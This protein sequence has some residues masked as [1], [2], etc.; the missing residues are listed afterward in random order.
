MQTV[1]NV[2]V[3]SNYRYVGRHLRAAYNFCALETQRA[4]IGLT[5]LKAK[6]G[7]RD[8]G[9]RTPSPFAPRRVSKEPISS[10]KQKT[11]LTSANIL[12]LQK[13]AFRSAVLHKNRFNPRIV[14]PS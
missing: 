13:Y 2:C 9:E 11:H 12:S 6:S 10:V 5:R 14:G 1:T 4:D 8:L 3:S 7:G